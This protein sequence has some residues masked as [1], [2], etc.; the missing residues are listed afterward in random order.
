MIPTKDTL[1]N[2]YYRL[3]EYN[4]PL[5]EQ[6]HVYNHIL[7]T[8]KTQEYKYRE[9]YYGVSRVTNDNGDYIIESLG[10]IKRA[11]KLLSI[12]SSSRITDLKHYIYSN[13]FV[14]ISAF[15]DEYKTLI[16]DRALIIDFEVGQL[17]ASERND[18][19]FAFYLRFEGYPTIDDLSAK[20][21]ALYK[22]I[23][24]TNVLFSRKELNIAIGTLNKI[25]GV[26]EPSF[27]HYLMYRIRKLKQEDLFAKE[28]TSS[29]VSRIP[30]GI[31]YLLYYKSNTKEL[32]LFRYGHSMLISTNEVYYNKT[33][34]LDGKLERQNSRY[35][36]TALDCLYDGT[37]ISK[38]TFEERLALLNKLKVNK[39]Y[40]SV[41]VNEITRCKSF[42][43][44]KAICE[45]LNI[46]NSIGLY[47]MSSGFTYA[48]RV[49]YC[50]LKDRTL[51][52]SSDWVKWKPNYEA[53]F[54]VKDKSF[55]YTL[56][57]DGTPKRYTDL[58]EKLQ[59]NI[60]N[61]TLSLHYVD[62]EFINPTYIYN[63]NSH[64]ED[65]I[66]DIIDR[67]NHRVDL[68]SF[69]H[70]LVPLKLKFNI[71]S[72]LK[73][74]PSPVVIYGD[75]I[76]NK[77]NDIPDTIFITVPQNGELSYDEI[78]QTI[79][80]KSSVLLLPSMIDY[81]DKSFLSHLKRLNVENIGIVTL[82][83]DKILYM[84]ERDSVY[85]TEYK[86][87]NNDHL[88][89]EYNSKLDYHIDKESKTLH[90]KEGNV[91]YK[92]THVERMN[93]TLEKEYSNY[94][95]LYGPSEKF[96]SSL[97]TTAILKRYNDLEP[98]TREP[99]TLSDNI[100]YIMVNTDIEG[101]FYDALLMS[102]FTKY[103]LGSFDVRKRYVEAL[104]EFS[105]VDVFKLATLLRFSI[106]VLDLNDK[107]DIKLLYNAPYPG[108]N[109]Y[110]VLGKVKDIYITIA[111]KVGNYLKTVFE[112]DNQHLKQFL[113]LKYSIPT[114]DEYYRLIVGDSVRKD[115]G[116]IVLE[117]KDFTELYLE[118]AGEYSVDY[119][120]LL[121]YPTNI[122]D[123]E[124]SVDEILA[125]N[126]SSSDDFTSAVEKILSNI[127]EGGNVLI[128]LPLSIYDSND[129]QL[130]IYS[131][132]NSF[133]EVYIYRPSGIFPSPIFVYGYSFSE[134]ME[135]LEK[136]M[137]K[138]I[139]FAF[140]S[141]MVYYHLTRLTIDEYQSMH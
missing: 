105:E 114:N 42:N 78:E 88:S 75:N 136:D 48:N 60:S 112:S 19:T 35:I 101:G 57:L 132:V 122:E 32:W 129:V 77:Y 4:C 44:F 17:I 6:K 133:D 73:K 14:A 37:D 49:D 8:Y 134:P 52:N 124:D 70:N 63:K 28:I 97:F 30:R 46:D 110:I 31:R 24:Q 2:D 3:W 117:D 23:L 87:N 94:M 58:R 10:D 123:I 85:A 121:E 21:E 54:I 120:T 47:I 59:D 34:V 41:L 100:E 118:V 15:E 27:N 102:Y 86:S 72:L 69:R 43:H 56:E 84:L 106:I 5:E 22:E 113:D 103:I 12:I 96:L 79:T 135:K 55:L 13:K 7:L 131:L 91:L 104:M 68:S 126:I 111:F 20:L 83:A 80:G 139:T 107:E 64:T 33:V 66:L 45:N 25:L 11:S 50:P 108:S 74:L 130:A 93:S 90:I 76:Y 40:F 62:D 82:D 67:T 51:L 128:N 138:D 61:A 29:Y 92:G 16:V 89:V 65:Q 98:D 125:E 36:Y 127:N 137:E 18:G 115:K 141:Q 53:R 81:S 9:S 99:V 71:E 38:L 109:K 140:I 95:D 39:P 116:P 26:E 119:G 1:N